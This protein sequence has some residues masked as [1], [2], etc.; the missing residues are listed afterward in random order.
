[1]KTDC[2]GRFA[3]FESVDEAQCVYIRAG[4][5]GK[6]WKI[7]LDIIQVLFE[8]RQDFVEGIRE[9]WSGDKL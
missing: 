8:Y 7:V 6:F 4:A 9:G 1:M 2:V 5:G 3:G